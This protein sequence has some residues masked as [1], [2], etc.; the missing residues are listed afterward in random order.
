MDINPNKCPMRFEVLEGRML[1]SDGLGG[2]SY[3]IGPEGPKEML[4]GDW[5]HIAQT[6][7]GTAQVKLLHCPR[8][9]PAMLEWKCD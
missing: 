6:R 1:L 4:F 5:L 7:S 2:D 8:S 3:D 9:V